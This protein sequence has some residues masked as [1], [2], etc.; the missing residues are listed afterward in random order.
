MITF[1][2]GSGGSVF[3][4]TKSEK[5]ISGEEMFC[6]FEESYDLFD[7]GCELH[8]LRKFVVAFEYSLPYCVPYCSIGT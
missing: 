2:N 5:K 6:I 8:C 3:Y 7:I 1:A 4:M